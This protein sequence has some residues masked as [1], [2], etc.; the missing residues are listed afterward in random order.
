MS[1]LSNLKFRS[2]VHRAFPDKSSARAARFVD[3]GQR[4]MQ[5]W[6]SGE[7]DVPENIAALVEVQGN[8]A[9]Q[10]NVRRHLEE[11]CQD[12]LDADGHPEAL[13]SIL[14]AL[15]MKHMGKPIE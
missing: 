1:Q 6:M 3:V 11:T 10:T 2:A 9:D 14:S 5:K 13:G 7:S 12:F 8:I 4:T 15:Y